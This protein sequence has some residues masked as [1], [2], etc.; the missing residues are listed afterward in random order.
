MADMSEH[1]LVNQVVSRLT[2][3]YPMVPAP[4]V[5]SIVHDIHA[6]FEGRP[7]RE[8]VPLFVERNA[9]AVLAKLNA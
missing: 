1:T 2:Q 8:F 9:L 4:T 6:K 7:L 5:A 3:K